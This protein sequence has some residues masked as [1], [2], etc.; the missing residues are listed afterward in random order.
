[1]AKGFETQKGKIE[2][3]LSLHVTVILDTVAGSVV[4]IESKIDFMMKIFQQKSE[5][6]EKLE[7]EVELNGGRQQV[8]GN[9][10]VL[11]QMADMSQG[12]EGPV[13]VNATLLYSLRSDVEELMEDNKA[14]FELKMVSLQSAVERSA[15]R[16]LTE[17]RAGAHEQIIQPVCNF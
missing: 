17:L 11:Q 10:V 1:M 8:L 6:E 3:C 14:M 12:S 15:E 16:I 5:I 2:F 4:Q 9:R 13:T 7:T